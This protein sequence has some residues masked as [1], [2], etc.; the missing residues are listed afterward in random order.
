MHQRLLPQI[1]T[2]HLETLSMIL[3]TT[4]Y[5][6]NIIH[7]FSYFSPLQVKNKPREGAMYDECAFILSP[8]GMIANTAAYALH[9]FYLSLEEICQLTVYFSSG[10]SLAIQ[11]HHSPPFAVRS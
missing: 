3:F 6:I 1:K 10:E 4:H 2:F 5:R 11:D 8:F 9:E 7:I